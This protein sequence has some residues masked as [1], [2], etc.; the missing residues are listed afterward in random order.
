MKRFIS[1]ILLVAALTT[2][3]TSCN[4]D[5]NFDGQTWVSERF[6]YN[7]EE[8]DGDFSERFQYDFNIT[9]TFTGEQVNAKINLKCVYNQTFLDEFGEWQTYTNIYSDSFTAKGTY[10]YDKKNVSISLKDKE[11]DLDE[12]WRGKVD[13]DK[14]T[15]NVVWDNDDTID[16]D[17]QVIF[18]KR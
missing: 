1:T 4:K 16:L 14:M 8:N 2:F 17:E 9:L 3:F 6:D 15:L 18:T 11:F 12:T 10:T 7:F 13:K 5:E